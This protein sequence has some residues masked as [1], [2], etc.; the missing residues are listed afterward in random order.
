MS[1][2]VPTPPSSSSHRARA[3]AVL[4]T[5]SDVGKS[6]VATALCRILRDAGLR[7]APYKAQN[8]SSTVAD[9]GNGQQMAWSQALQADAA[10]V[11]CHHDMNPILLKP[12]PGM[13]SEVIIR[14]SRLDVESAA[15][16]MRKVPERVRIA[17]ESYDALAAHYD[18]IVIEG[19][20]S[21]AE[22]N[23][24]DTD[25]VN[26]RA[27]RYA[28][29]PVI[30]VGDIARGGVFAQLLGTLD[31]LPPDDRA[32]VA[33]L[34]VNQFRGD[35]SLFDNGVAMIEERGGKPVLGV[36]PVLD[37]LDFVGPDREA[38]IARWAAHVRAHLALDA[39]LAPLCE[40][41]RTA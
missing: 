35:R 17:E 2:A 18:V 40:G 13:R 41:A 23:L 29:A 33:G 21:A 39:V 5:A 38:S 4:G 30:L 31:L 6:L 24:W 8:M 14:G 22:I 19:A 25:L 15:T 11:A 26:W 9:Y 12:I 37:G 36:L 3:I 34:V 27:A 32:R 10:G 1:A 28:D 16:W 20:G 7:V